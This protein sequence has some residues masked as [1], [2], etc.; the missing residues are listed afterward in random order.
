MPPEAL[1]FIVLGLLF[2]VTPFVAFFLALAARRQIRDLEGKVRILEARLNRQQFLQPGPRETREPDALPIPPISAP[3]PLPLA[4]AELMDVPRTAPVA[5]PTA[6][7]PPAPS[8]ERPPAPRE[9]AVSIPPLPSAPPVRPKPVAAPALSLEERLGT[10]FFVWVGAVA[11]ALAGTYLVKYT[12]DQGL[13]SPAVRVV[14]GSLFGL[15]L[16]A[17]GEFLRKR[18]ARIAQAVS[19]AG[20]ADLFAC[21]L[22][23]TNL[24]KLISPTTGFALMA[25]NTA[26]AV[27][28][29]L[30]QGP[31]VA[32]LGMAGGFLTPVLIHTG[33]ARVSLFAYLFMLEIGLV[34]VTRKRHWPLLTGIT[35]L[36]GMGW[37]FAWTLAFMHADHR[38]WLGMFVL[39]SA[40]LATMEI[41]KEF[42]AKDPKANCASCHVDK[43][44]KKD[45]A[46]LNDFGKTVKAA[47]GADGKIDWTKVTVPAAK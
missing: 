10:R 24:Y 22:A 45:K 11:L 31:F 6:P 8:P 21:L 30:R 16:L 40:A 4:P 23:A 35:L 46:D 19:A 9:P 36:C 14:L 26:L 5:P 7:W 15:T 38:F 28:L 34:A 13:I 47:K 12:F 33:E 27:A 1:F 42:K 20:V 2:L 37:A 41:Q 39:G 3:A 25:A 18:T 32:A 17:V 29:S 43:M 44:P